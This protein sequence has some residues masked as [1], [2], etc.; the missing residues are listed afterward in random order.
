MGEQNRIPGSL[1]SSIL[2]ALSDVIVIVDKNY[3]YVYVSPACL[4]VTGYSA[5]EFISGKVPAKK[6]VHPDDYFRLLR[7]NIKAFKSKDLPRKVEFR[8][9]KKDGEIRWVSMVW[10]VV[11]DEAGNIKFLQGVMR[12]ITE[13]KK[14]EEELKKKIKELELLHNLSVELSGVTS[15]DEVSRLIYE[16]ITSFV[17]VLGFFIDI[18]DEPSGQIKGLTHVYTIHGRKVMISHPNYRY[19]VESSDLLKEVILNKKTVLLKYTTGNVPAPFDLFIDETMPE[20]Y[21]LSLPMLSEDKIF[22]IMTIQT[23]DVGKIDEH[24]GT[25]ENIATQTAIALERVIYFVQLQESEKSLR[26]AYEELKKAQRQLA[27]SEKMKSLGELAS[28]VAHNLSNLLST[29]LG[30]TQLLKTKLKDQEHIKNLEFIEKAVKD[31]SRIVSRIREF[32]RPRTH[33]NLLPIDVVPVI[34]DALEIT[35]SKWKS[36]AEAKGIKYEII[37][38]YADDRYL[39]VTN[40]SELREALVNIILNALDAMPEGGKLTVGVKNSN[41]NKVAIYIQDTGI[42]MDAE[43]MSK[44]FD[45]FFTT[46]GSAGTGLG[47]SIVYEIVKSHGGE[48]TVE[49]EP[50]EGSKFTIFLKASDKKAAELVKEKTRPIAT[51]EGK[52]TVFV[53]DDD[54]SVLY[55]L[56][57]IFI[58]QNYGVI[59]ADSGKKAMEVIK[60]AE[61][62]LAVIDLV[63]PDASGWE[64]TEKIKS[65][66][67]NIPVILL[68]GWTVDDTMEELQKKGV[69]FVL[70]KPFDLDDLTFVVS[71]AAQVIKK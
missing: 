4:H 20:G 64:I 55:L 11:K 2:N 40:A 44:I 29:I 24:R 52:L 43:T 14:F 10:T 6:I 49:S 18:F 51:K 13:R 60:D 71:Q 48:I 56:K 19:K 7:E 36:E 16:Y 41:E 35:K 69:D 25:L 26:E 67:K 58:Q 39:A 21:L 33:V 27:L 23:T 61:F 62:D 53:V 5:D 47:L 28:G 31:A 12:D 37:K 70:A 8:I 1:E 59:I 32:A 22:G 15:V 17:P 54:Q 45:P 68:T 42:G 50:G 46:K 38:D 34:E 3:N 9:V 30:R 63:L 65:K 57:D 66:N